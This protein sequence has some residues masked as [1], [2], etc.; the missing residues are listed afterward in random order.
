MLTHKHLLII[1]IC[2]WDQIAEL[3]ESS[4]YSIQVIQMTNDYSAM[5]FFSLKI[6]I[7]F[8]PLLNIFSFFLFQAFKGRISNI[9]TIKKFLQPGSA[10][11][12]PMNEKMAAEVIK[13]FH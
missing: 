1:T 13:T 6:K 2:N 4:K 11:N 9:P 8:P 12:P 7:Y 3:N 10:R 5:S